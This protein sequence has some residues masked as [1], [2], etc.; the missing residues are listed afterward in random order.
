[1][2][3][4]PKG[5]K[6]ENTFWFSLLPAHFYLFKVTVCRCNDPPVII[7]CK[8]K[9]QFIPYFLILRISC[10]LVSY[11][12]RSKFQWSVYCLFPVWLSPRLWLAWSWAFMYSSA[13]AFLWRN[14]QSSPTLPLVHKT[15]H[16]PSV[17]SDVSETSSGDARTPVT[18]FCKRDCRENILSSFEKNRSIVALQRCVGFRGLAKWFS[19]LKLSDSQSL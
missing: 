16:R 8:H 10:S 9:W 14:G 1:M 17:L 5:N 15:C 3:K 11:I 7:I 2:K 13:G 4:T 19:Y 6:S 18:A 12:C